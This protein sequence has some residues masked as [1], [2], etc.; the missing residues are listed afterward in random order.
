LRKIASAA[1]GVWLA[2]GL[3][4]SALPAVASAQALDAKLR[5]KPITVA[6]EVEGSIPGF[7]PEQLSAFVTQQMADAHLTAWRFAAATPGQAGNEPP[8][9]VVWQFKVLPYA[10]G[11]VRYIGPALSKARDIF[12]AGRPIG[13][14]AKIY[15]DGKFQST[16]FDQATV[17]GGPHDPGLSDLIKKVMTS[18]VANAFAAEPAA[19]P[20]LAGLG[21]VKSGSTF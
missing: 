13:A 3:M 15:L 17:K 11:T 5:D 9:R 16:S 14:D 4:I 2:I 8:N 20:K 12:G 19:G 18:I 10:G 7:T 6:V 1:N 21:A